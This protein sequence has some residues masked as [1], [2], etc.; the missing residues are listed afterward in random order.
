MV[1]NFLIL[2]RERVESYQ[3]AMPH[4]CISVRDPGTEKAVLSNDMSRLDAL[5]LEFD[6]LDFKPDTVFGREPVM[7]NDG[8]AALILGFYEKWKEKVDVFVI[9]CEAGIS[10]SAGIGAALCKIS[11]YDDSIFFKK[12]CPN[13]FVYRTILNRRYGGYESEEKD[14]GQN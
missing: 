6:D 9:N 1:K 7:F 3:L 11:G 4:A 13:R 12:F 2:S 10:R 5:Y 8:H 14:K